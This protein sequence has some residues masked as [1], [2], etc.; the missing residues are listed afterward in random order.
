MPS[1]IVC[2]DVV[3]MVSPPLKVPQ[4][5][6]GHNEGVRMGVMLKINV[7][8]NSVKQCDL[9]CRPSKSRSFSQQFYP[10]T[11]RAFLKVALKWKLS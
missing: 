5:E 2:V 8:R 1:L 7:E 3:A 10:L 6:G 4:I 9:W 11:S